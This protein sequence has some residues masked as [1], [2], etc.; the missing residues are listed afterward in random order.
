M[1]DNMKRQ[2]KKRQK[3]IR[4]VQIIILS[5][6][7]GLFPVN[8]KAD[9]ADQSSENVQTVQPTESNS[10][11]G[12]NDAKKEVKE[13]SAS[14]NLNDDRL[15]ITRDSNIPACDSKKNLSS[16]LNKGSTKALDN[17]YSL[18]IS[19]GG[20]SGSTVQYILVKYT[21]VNGTE[22]TKLLFPRIDAKQRSDALAKYTIFRNFGKLMDEYD[23][24]D[25]FSKNML[26][27]LNYTYNL[28][29]EEPLGEWTT[30]DILFQTDTKIQRID[31]VDV[32]M[33]KGS[34]AVQ[35]A[36]IYKVDRI[37]GYA[38]YGFVSGNRFL[39][40]EGSMIASF[41]KKGVNPV[42]LSTGE[43][44][45]MFSLGEADENKAENFV[46][47]TYEE[48]EVKRKLASR[49]DVY[50]FRFDF[51]DTKDSGIES[52]L[53]RVKTKLQNDNGIV[54]DIVME[55]QYKDKHGWTRKVTLPVIISSFMTARL[56]EPKQAIIGMAQRGDT[57]AFQGVYPDFDKVVSKPVLYVG[58][59][60][61]E[62]MSAMGI[63]IDTRNNRVLQTKKTIDKDSIS[64]AGMSMYK[65]GCMAY[66][67]GG[68]DSSGV[69]YNGATLEYVF[70]SQDPFLYYT[71]VEENGR[72]IQGGGV[73][74]IPLTT[75]RSGDPLVANQNLQDKYLVT[76]RTSRV[77]MSGTKSDVSLTLK[78]QTV[79]NKI[80]YT[81]S[82]NIRNEATKFMSEWPS[83]NNDDYTYTNG[84]IEGGNLSFFVEAPQLKSFTG[85]EI[86]LLG[87]DEWN[88]SD[89]IISY[90]EKCG[91][92][93]S[94]NIATETI[95]SN[96]WIEREMVSAVF[97]RLSEREK[98]VS[99]D[100]GK[101]VNATGDVIDKS[102]EGVYRE[103]ETT[104][105]LFMPNQTLSFSFEDRKVSEGEEASYNDV[106]YKMSYEQ[107]SHNWQFLKKRK[108]YDVAV[109][110]ASDSD[111]DDGNG[112]SGSKNYFY[113]QLI[114]KNGNSAYVL[115]NQQ[116][117][118][119]AFH[120]GKTE[121][122]TIA[123]NRDYGDLKSVRII[124]EDIADS[125]EPFDKLN[126]DNITVSEQTNGG[127]CM[128]YFIDQVGWLD[129]DYHD[130]IEGATMRGKTARGENE[131]SKSFKVTHKERAVNILCEMTIL[132]WDGNYKNFVGSMSGEIEY[133]SSSTNKIEKKS[134]DIV[135]R[136]AAYMNKS[137]IS[138]ERET[139]PEAEKMYT[140][141]LHSVSDENWM[142][143]PNHTDRFVL[144]AISDL[145]SIKSITL[146]AASR[147]GYPAKLNIGKFDVYQVIKDGSV[148]LNFNSEYYRNMKLKWLCGKT[149]EG[150]ISTELPIGTPLVLPKITFGKNE[151]KWE[152]D[153]W[154]TPVS[155]LPDSTDDTV[156]VYVYPSADSVSEMST[157]K[158][159]MAL[160][161]AI[162][163]S[164]YMQISADNMSIM[165]EGSDNPYFYVKG[166]TVKDFVNAQSLALQCTNANMG[167][168]YAVVQHV[169]EDVVVATYQYDFN[170][171]S[172]ILSLEAE[173]G[174][175]VTRLEKTEQTIAVSFGEGTEE[176][177]LTPEMKDVAVA[178]HYTSTLD[179]GAKEYRSP[180][181]YLSDLGY[182]SISEGLFAEFKY[183]IPCVDKITGYSIAGYGKIKAN[184]D[185]ACGANY[186][187]EAE[188]EDPETG[189]ITVTKRSQRSYASFADSF[190]LNEIETKHDRTSKKEFG[191]G[192]V[193][194]VELTLTTSAATAESES[195]TDA[196]VRMIFN[197]RNNKGAKV[198]KTKED[199]TPYIQGD[200]KKF[201]TGKEATVKLMLPEMNKDLTLI[202]IDILP[203]N[204]K[205]VSEISTEILAVD[206]SGTNE[207]SI[208][209]SKNPEK[210][211]E[212]NLKSRN[213][214]W[215]ISKVVCKIGYGE[216]GLGSKI[217][218]RE[219]N[220]EFNGATGGGSL[221]LNNVTQMVYY[222]KTGGIRTQVK[223]HLSQILVQ[224]GDT[225]NGVVVVTDSSEGFSAKAY[226]MVGEAQDDADP[227][228]LTKD[229]NL[230]FTFTAPANT[231]G[232]VDI[233][234]IEIS[235]VDAPDIVDVIM[236]S[237]ESQ[238]PTPTPE[239]TQS[240]TTVP[241]ESP[242]PTQSPTPTLQ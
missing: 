185:G 159:K 238:T 104:D 205:I 82:Y 209:G 134:F 197:Y 153:S 223:D 11:Q 23:L 221:R 173:P 79:D 94:Y 124:P 115:A 19:T 135:S 170:G 110:V 46:I 71:T 88:M 200:V 236:V 121:T 119:D 162:P 140:E 36:A 161:Y 89:L 154:A 35:G 198:T 188:E 48:G 139:D 181:V 211:L 166:L 113:F 155:R 40:Y 203:Y 60:A 70:D 133:I 216:L 217:I 66:V 163:F 10:N 151:I 208:T 227:S 145:K 106:R 14:N 222:T 149:N 210:V 226:R 27:S 58:K 182:T 87:D 184:V 183:N 39:D 73:D 201:E 132:P 156:N 96:Y 114:F 97:F 15:S 224:P 105:Q 136:I 33:G 31:N 78:Y 84:M 57:I 126:I 38:S 204:G 99:N 4:I 21:D 117:S 239:P 128:V 2:D 101:E 68:T 107:T 152:S 144:P 93:F 189:E 28:K 108:L 59:P 52:Y 111:Y 16:W 30:Q 218:E 235:P 142:F 91:K 148:Q 56:M 51:A 86:S 187:V 143:R 125:S 157:R 160:Q 225:V 98:T 150:V 67:P 192:A 50:T 186:L 172:A 77:P 9:K 32:Y 129:I 72:I 193:T 24:S 230:N 178:F 55:L 83:F 130:E 195:G 137:V 95:G 202:S 191:E 1:E 6:L 22:R 234:K 109:K 194:P 176:A 215:S 44:D 12:I 131:I 190:S 3:N 228:I 138:G 214:S 25:S 62:K 168:E 207:V 177:T 165:R 102:E 43:T 123:T 65:G 147:N 18:T 171:A 174:L 74:E 206:A 69:D 41:V 54:E 13:A 42:S 49:D 26:G 34:W 76:I 122:F 47:K 141:E 63:E 146:T 20:K 17:T 167:F 120:S 7:I 158:V 164:Q 100:D 53:N 169:R 92:R 127:A 242:T 231:S 212:K 29:E 237:V 103:E 180:Y 45:S 112:D 219:V 64:L 232:T 5:F 61:R 116:I 179:N 90:V 75:Y 241:K 118:G 85:A 81:K 8:S 196:Q 233:Y 240:P 199:I 80:E 175:S 220:Q 37:C 229:G 213:A